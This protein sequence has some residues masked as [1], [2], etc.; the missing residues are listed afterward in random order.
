[1]IKRSF[2]PAVFSLFLLACNAGLPFSAATPTPTEPAVVLSF[3]VTVIPLGPTATAT[4]AATATEMPTPTVTS[5][6]L[7]I[8]PIS[9]VTL[10]PT[11]TP[12]PAPTA[13]PDLVNLPLSPVESPT[14]VVTPTVAAAPAQATSSTGVPTAGILTL[15]EPEQN[16]IIPAHVNALDFKWQWRGS[17]GC[18]GLPE[19]YGFELRIWPAVTGF[20]PEGVMDAVANQKDIGC[21]LKTGIYNYRVIDLRG[22]PG[23]KR[24]NGTGKFLWD[25]AYIQLEPYNVI[26]ASQP[27][28]FEVASQ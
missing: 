15:I 24:T 1:M 16:T 5:T 25:I 27:G 3:N 14:A 2:I 17:L 19:G 18:S 6:P 28:L 11:H 7:I 8:N 26:L 12:S 9:P 20:G 10:P 13:T 22:T 23:V 21:D 4:A